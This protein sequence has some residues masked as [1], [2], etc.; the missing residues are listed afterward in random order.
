MLMDKEKDVQVRRKHLLRHTKISLHSEM[1][2]RPST[3]LP[4]EFGQERYLRVHV[5][6]NWAGCP[7]TR[8]CPSGALVLLFGCPFHCV[9]KTQS[10]TALPSAKSELSSIGTCAR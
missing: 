9:F 1:P 5:D 7:S 4:A 10:A 8:K 3:M 6:A 2:L